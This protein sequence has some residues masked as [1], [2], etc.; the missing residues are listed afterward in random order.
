[1]LISSRCDRI[2]WKS[3]VFP[4]PDPEEEEVLA[5]SVGRPRNRVSQLFQNA[6]RPLRSRRESTS[7]LSSLERDHGSASGHHSPTASPT[8]ELGD[9]TP[10]TSP[11]SRFTQ[12][13]T[14]QLT[15]SHSVEHISSIVTK[16]TS[17][18]P[19]R[20]PPQ[21]QTAGYSDSSTVLRSATSIPLVQSNTIQPIVTT[22][23]RP[24]SSRGRTVSS[25][26][27]GAPMSANTPQGAGA[28][29]STLSAHKWSFLK[30]LSR[31]SSQTSILPERPATPDP[32]TPRYPRKGEVMCLDYR[33]LDD[34]GMRKLEGRSD[35]RPV[36]GS[37]AI[38]V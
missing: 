6:L 21:P 9:P 34:K 8:E 17:R 30:F 37:Y 14:P 1:M 25:S 16:P 22:P 4:E 28:H 23:R 32:A 26:S 38:Y 36:I 13:G 29:G 33:T 3:T 2:L 35:H 18:R 31:D 15:K 24:T 5:E 19:P 20:T 10:P 7:T 27:I 11:F 12:H